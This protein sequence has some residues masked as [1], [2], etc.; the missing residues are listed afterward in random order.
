MATDN[1]QDNKQDKPQAARAGE[2][3]SPR[4]ERLLG[5]TRH[6]AHRKTPD[7]AEMVREK[8]FILFV[9]HALEGRVVEGGRARTDF[10]NL[11]RVYVERGSTLPAAASAIYEHIKASHDGAQ[12]PRTQA[13][14]P[15]RSP[16]R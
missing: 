4:L 1:K 10:E 6:P 5:A 8:T 13:P 11:R 9:Q 2:N 15:A 12:A 16:N 14:T 3:L 7:Q